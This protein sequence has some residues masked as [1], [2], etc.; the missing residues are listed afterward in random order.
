MPFTFGISSYTKIGPHSSA[1]SDIHT[2]THTW[3]KNSS[4]QCKGAG[5]AYKTPSSIKPGRRCLIP[6]AGL[7]Q[8]SKAEMC[9]LELHWYKWEGAT[10]Q[11][12]TTMVPSLF[13]LSTTA[14]IYNTIALLTFR[15]SCS[16][17]FC[18]HLRRGN[19]K[20]GNSWRGTELLSQYQGTM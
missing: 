9:E 6:Y 18:G 19:G 7:L 12:L 5:L 15:A 16:L 8:S 14:L 1:F 20:K 13:H 3:S 11:V 4:E 10:Y 17:L 2:H